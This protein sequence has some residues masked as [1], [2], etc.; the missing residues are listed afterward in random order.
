[1]AIM[2]VHWK[3]SERKISERAWV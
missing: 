2:T 1:M 3:K